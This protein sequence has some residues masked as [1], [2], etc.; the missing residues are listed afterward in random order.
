MKKKNMITIKNSQI[1][2]ETIDSINYLTELEMN[3]SMAFKFI[4]LIKELSIIVDNKSTSE[5]EILDRWIEKDENGNPS[6]VKDSNGNVI[7]D[8]VNIIDSDSF[9]REMNELMEV[10]H[11]ID[12]DKVNFYELGLKTARIKD[13]IILEFLFK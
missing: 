13:L 7:T 12:F 11:N 1:N 5:R 3:A 6:L 8:S 10:E 9:T 4:S 2:K